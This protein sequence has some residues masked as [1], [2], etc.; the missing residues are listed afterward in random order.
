MGHQ[1]EDELY[2]KGAT[3][4]VKDNFPVFDRHAHQAIP[5]V[6]FHEH[7]WEKEW[8]APWLHGAPKGRIAIE[9]RRIPPKT[10]CSP[11]LGALCANAHEALD[12][13]LTSMASKYYKRLPQIC[14][15]PFITILYI[16]E[17]IRYKL[18]FSSC[19]EE[20]YCTFGNQLGLVCTL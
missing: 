19:R 1:Q 16:I 4:K 18:P 5:K 14:S 8:N 11:S 12:I 13:F 9:W 2:R 3:E 6:C 15:D 10:Q 17:Q 20:N 7:Q